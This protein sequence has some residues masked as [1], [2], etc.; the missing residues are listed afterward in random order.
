MNGA[1]IHNIN[2]VETL[3]CCKCKSHCND[4]K[5]IKTKEAT[6]KK[7]ARFKWVCDICYAGWVSN[8][9]SFTWNY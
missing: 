7:S 8:G 5:G 9:G 4:L 2:G 3:I 1:K 6:E